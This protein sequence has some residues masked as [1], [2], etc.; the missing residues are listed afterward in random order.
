MGSIGAN[1][2][3]PSTMYSTAKDFKNDLSQYFTLESGPRAGEYTIIEEDT[4]LGVIRFSRDLGYSTVRVSQGDH[5]TSYN[6][7]KSVVNVLR[8][9]R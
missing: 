6:N 5:W 4:P 9:R 3:V 2:N 7:L 1:N 8:K